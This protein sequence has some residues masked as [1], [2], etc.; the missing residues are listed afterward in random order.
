MIWLAWLD[1]M[2]SVV[3]V[4]LLLSGILL[5]IWLIVLFI[6]ILVDRSRRKKHPK[7]FELFDAAMHESSDTQSNRLFKAA[8]KYA[9]DN[10]LKWGFLYD[11]EQE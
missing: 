2:L 8:D 9:R 4:L 5:L 7:Y 3:H 6:N 10:G 1:I 11:N